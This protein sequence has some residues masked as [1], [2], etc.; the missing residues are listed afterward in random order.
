MTS[1]ERLTWLSVLR[2]QNPSLADRLEELLS[3]HRVLE[4]E[5]FLEGPSIGAL[6]GS[7]LSGQPLG[8]YTLI[9]QIGMG[10]MGS[11][12]LAERN[13]ARFE[14]KV[15]VKL[16]KIAFL[17]KPVEERFQREGVILGRLVHPNIAQL[18]DAGVSHAG[19]PYLVLEHVEGD[20]ID[21]YCDARRLG[22]KERVRLFLDVLH[23]VAYAHDN[24]IVHRD[25]K[26]ANILV[27][28]DGQ[29][30]L[31]DFG[32]AKLLQDDEHCCKAAATIDAGRAMTPEYAAPE[33]LTG[34]PA[35]PATDVYG[36]GVL[37]Y[38]LLT[39]RHPAGPGPHSPADLIKTI[40]DV[41]PALP[42]DVAAA[43]K[44]RILRGD[45]DTI[46]AKALKKNPADRYASVRTFAEDLQQYLEQ[47]P[48]SA[49]RDAIG[50]RIKRFIRRNQRIVAAGLAILLMLAGATV[51]TRSVSLGREAPAQYQQRRLT[52]NPR[53]LPVLNA[54]I[55]P[56]GQ[57]LGYADREGLHLQLIETG[58]TRSLPAPPALRAAAAYWWFGSWYPDSSRFIASIAIPGTPASLWLVS[59]RDGAWQKVTDVE[60]LV[61]AGVVSPDGSQIAYRRA[62]NAYG[63]REIWLMDSQSQS[64]HRILT[65]ED[66]SSFGE[67]AWSPAGGRIAY[68]YTRQRGDRLEVSVQ[69]C[70]L[71]GRDNKT[72]VHDDALS[73]SAWLPS[74][75]FIYSRST[76]RGTTGAAE[77]REL[78][79][80]E[81]GA[82]RGESRRIADWSGFSIGYFSATRDGERLVFL[83]R[84]YHSSAFVADI[85]RDGSHLSNS[86][87]LIPDD[88]INIAL[89]WT[90]D[91]R[92][93]IFSSQ[94]AATRRMYR[95]SLA[96][97]SAPQIV[98][99][100]TDMNFYMARF[101]PDGD[102]LL[103]EGEPVTSKKLGIYRTEVNGG[104]PELLFPVNGLTQYWCSN[105]LAGVCVLGRTA[106]AGNELV[107]SSFKPS[108]GDGKEWLRIPL[109]R[110][111]GAEVGSDYSWQL[112]PDGSWIGILK[113]HCNQ[114][115]IV[116]L[117]G[118][119]A[120][121]ITVG[122]YPDLIDLNWAA[123]SQSMFVS[124]L[125]PQGATLLHVNLNGHARPIWLQAQTTWLWGFPSP[126]A[127][128]LAISTEAPD[129]NVWMMKHF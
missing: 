109:E 74:G 81:G 83:R 107:I 119:P 53:E 76:Q 9:S 78:Q 118:G 98:T 87:Q 94:R 104:A 37:L 4:R 60:N 90:P 55:S 96:P 89:A 101:S 47:K 97:G 49:R 38:L 61:G 25:L 34:A 113:R 117:D 41:E 39:G 13:D 66:R 108:G 15:A 51:I 59:I 46:T 64:P 2:T 54:V 28:K 5:E 56:D 124:S 72:I 18:I 19:Q 95:Q 115:R 3:H 1:E 67:I 14:R 50:Y 122:G 30:K 69:S 24:L 80:A 33:Q 52:A 68:T 27:R 111:A 116:P 92:E 43:P 91:S 40:L 65:A 102:S 75:R 127:R 86:R 126:D 63:A 84:S 62:Q 128:H 103:L 105:R 121:I 88:N 45:L 71:I 70:N 48:I 17:G 93:V 21:R 106:E 31:L 26:P 35:T 8:A 99:P 73:A 114:I 42:S 10:G 7:G 129:A 77:L 29:V 82:P 85:S 12:W 57:Y 36:L 123:D 120:R 23:A 16:L 112:S 6:V 22:I 44:C 20:H 79:V 125:E 11:V 58:E 110:G 32:I 100:G